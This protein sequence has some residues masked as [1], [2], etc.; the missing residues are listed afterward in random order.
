MMN[1]QERYIAIMK[2]CERYLDMFSNTDNTKE[3]LIELRSLTYAFLE[4]CE[5]GEIPKMCQWLE[6]IQGILI[7]RGYTTAEAE[8]EWTALFKPLDNSQ[9]I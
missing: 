3:E 7:E 6:H 1:E 8:I 9:K 4:F 2:C 5:T